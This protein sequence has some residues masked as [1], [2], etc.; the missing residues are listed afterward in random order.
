MLVYPSS[1][2]DEKPHPIALALVE[3]Q[4]N[5]L[6]CELGQLKRDAPDWPARRKVLVDEINRLTEIAMELKENQAKP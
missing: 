6:A 4:L 1:M 2:P 5:D 3:K